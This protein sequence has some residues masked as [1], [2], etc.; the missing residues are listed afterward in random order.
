MQLRKG[1]KCVFFSQGF[2]PLKLTAHNTLSQ[3]L[4]QP[5]NVNVHRE[6][7]RWGKTAGELKSFSRDYECLQAWA[8]ESGS[9]GSDPAPSWLCGLGRVAEPLC[10]LV[11]SLAK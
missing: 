5:G 1:S 7:V 6:T 2:T 8:P 10:A 11:L 3:L 9:L 4:G